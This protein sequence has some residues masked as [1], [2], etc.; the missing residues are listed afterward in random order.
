MHVALCILMSYG[1]MKKSSLSK[2]KI[3]T[4]FGSDYIVNIM[5]GVSYTN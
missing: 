2:T 4:T 5:S 3:K 1:E